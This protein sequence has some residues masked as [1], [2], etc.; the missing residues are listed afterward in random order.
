MR[1]VGHYSY[2]FILLRIDHLLYLEIMSPKKRCKRSVRTGDPPSNSS[3]ESSFYELS[4]VESSASSHRDKSLTKRKKS[5]HHGKSFTKKQRVVNT[6]QRVREILEEYSEDHDSDSPNVQITPYGSDPEFVRQLERDILFQGTNTK[7]TATLTYDVFRKSAQNSLHYL[8]YI[9][10]CKTAQTNFY[11]EPILGLKYPLV[12]LIRDPQAKW[13]VSSGVPGPVVSLVLD[14]LCYYQTFSKTQKKNLS[15]SLRRFGRR[16]LDKGTYRSPST[17]HGSLA[18]LPPT[19]IFQIGSVK[20]PSCLF[21]ERAVIKLFNEIRKNG[22][23]VLQGTS[24]AAK[25]IAELDSM[26]LDNKR[27]RKLNEEKQNLREKIKRAEDGIAE[28]ERV[29][30]EKLEQYKMVAAAD[31]AFERLVK[32]VRKLPLNGLEG[33]C[34]AMVRR[35]LMQ[36]DPPPRS[37]VDFINVTL[38]VQSDWR[39]EPKPQCFC[40]MRYCWTSHMPRLRAHYEAPRQTTVVRHPPQLTPISTHSRSD[41]VMTSPRTLQ[42]EQL[43]IIPEEG[44]QSEQNDVESNC[45]SVT[46]AGEGGE[47]D[48]ERGGVSSAHG[49]E[50]EQG[51]RPKRSRRG[52]A[53]NAAKKCNV[54]LRSRKRDPSPV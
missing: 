45:A 28:Y 33:I 7:S 51:T 50:A 52:G 40:E 47:S 12:H 3:S 42:E 35:V 29:L 10:F 5:N 15:K 4:D 1:V 32:H 27:L 19:S 46:V 39:N 49:S 41:P 21:K 17:I 53:S 38:E 37:L 36:T 2:F 11:V 30:H 48:V 8:F 9:W 13:D 43:P 20:F 34:L 14:S 6:E 16:L 44:L 23:G 25:E 24:A 26:E 31:D 18:T 54:F 22:F